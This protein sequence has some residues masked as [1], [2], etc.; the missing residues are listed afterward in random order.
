MR[1]IAF[2]AGILCAMAGS[3]ATARSVTYQYQGLPFGYGAPWQACPA[4]WHGY[5]VP[6]P[7]PAEPFNGS[8]TIDESVFPG[9]TVAGASFRLSIWERYDG[10]QPCA[11]GSFGTSCYFYEIKGADGTSMTDHSEQGWDAFDFF[12]FDGFLRDFID[13]SVNYG[14]F[15]WQFDAAGNVASWQGGNG[16]G[17]DCDPFSWGRPDGRGSDGY[18]SGAETQG[19]GVWTRVPPVAEVPLPAT[20]LSLASGL[21]LSA[22]AGLRRRSRQTSSPDLH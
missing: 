7:C 21:A 11:D 2:V 18:L 16:C 22:V 8:L 13:Y 5:P 3:A 20:M 4:T 10:S 1:S 6:D 15:W 17:G 9:A 19:Q 12:S 14:D